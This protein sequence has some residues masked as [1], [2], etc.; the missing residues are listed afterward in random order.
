[1]EIF[2]NHVLIAGAIAWLIAQT[3]KVPIEYLRTQQ[4]N[5]ALLFRAG[6]M[7]SSHSALVTAIAHAIGLFYGF[8]SPLFAIGLTLAMVVV[9]DATGIRRQAGKHAELINAIINDLASG[10]PLKEEQLREVLGHTP[11]EAFAGVALGVVVAQLVWLV[12]S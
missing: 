10:H 6:G 7:P 2:R 4:W 1:M 9:Y 11:I 5:W 3:V 12:A 8:D